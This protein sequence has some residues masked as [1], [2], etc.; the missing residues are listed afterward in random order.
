MK[1]SGRFVAL[2]T[3]EA[4]PIDE[5]RAHHFVGSPPDESGQLVV[6]EE[7]PWPKVLLI[8][9]GQDAGF[10]LYRY[11][12]NGQFAGDTWHLT[13]DEAREQAD[14]EFGEGLSPWRTV[15]EEIADPVTFALHE[16]EVH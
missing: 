7:F 8:R 13:L 1:M 11:A 5:R 2:V 6:H 12:Q 9:P 10:M 16:L 3:S 15:P 4:P 14:F